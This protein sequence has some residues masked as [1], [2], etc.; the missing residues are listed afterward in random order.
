MA[1]TSMTAT[2]MTATLC[3]GGRGRRKNHNSCKGSRSLAKI[4]LVFEPKYRTDGGSRLH[5]R[6]GNVRWCLW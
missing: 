5:R 2:T 4:V 1:A 3:E 6:L